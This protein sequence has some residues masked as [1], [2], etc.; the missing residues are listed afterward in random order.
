MT[1]IAPNLS[2]LFLFYLFIFFLNPNPIQIP[3]LYIVAAATLLF[4]PSLLLFFSLCLWFFIANA[5]QLCAF[6]FESFKFSYLTIWSMMSDGQVG[7]VWQFNALCV[8]LNPFSFSFIPSLFLF[9]FLCA[10]IHSF[11]LLFIV[12]IVLF[13]P[14]IP[15]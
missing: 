12:N 4:S 2:F 8:F 10:S 6:S 7:V 5:L 1:K 15:G 9:P 3:F 14:D 13:F 11:H